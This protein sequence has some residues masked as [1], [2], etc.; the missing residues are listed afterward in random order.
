ML[1][2]VGGS[3][4][5]VI[6][7]LGNNGWRNP[8]ADGDLAVFDASNPSNELG[9]SG[10]HRWFST[11]QNVLIPPSAVA[12]GTT[13][14]RGFTFTHPARVDPSLGSGSD[15]NNELRYELLTPQRETFTYY[16]ILQPINY[17]H[18]SIEVVESTLPVSTFSDWAIGDVLVSGNN[19]ATMVIAA[20]GEKNGL[21]KLWLK[22]LTGDNFAS[23]NAATL[24]NM[25]TRAQQTMQVSKRGFEPENNKWSIQWTDDGGPS[26]GYSNGSYLIST[27]TN[28]LTTPDSTFKVDATQ[29]NAQ[30]S[31]RAAFANEITPPSD[32]LVDTADNGRIVE[33]WEHRLKGTD[34]NSTD[35]EM[36]IW[37]KQSR[38]GAPYSDWGLLYQNTSIPS[39]DTHFDNKFTHGYFQGYANSGFEEETTTY[40]MKWRG[41]N[42][43]P[44]EL[45]DAGV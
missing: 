42:T 6:P 37:K 16:K 3:K 12:D 18:R 44:Q 8:V 21:C 26:N 1:H 28:A 34:V 38:A 43:K 30:P 14:L 7:E 5:I 2:V 32:L 4:S 41:R 31:N 20:K 17:V 24:T 23:L 22:N 33:Y 10:I 36:R 25:Q 39:F 9:T 19:S 15:S 11:R 13:G 27:T 40:L 35:G 29:T 45:I